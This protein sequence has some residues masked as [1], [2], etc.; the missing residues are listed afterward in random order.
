MVELCKQFFKGV[1]VPVK[2]CRT[3]VNKLT[4]T[5]KC[6]QSLKE[7][8]TER[9][10][11]LSFRA[12]EVINTGTTELCRV[13]ETATGYKHMYMRMKIKLLPQV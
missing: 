7:E 5:S 1:V 9:P 13:F 2:L 11:D 8:F 3:G 4:I 6:L 12:E 10:G